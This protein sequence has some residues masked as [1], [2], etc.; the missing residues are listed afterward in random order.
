MVSTR[1]LS[2]EDWQ[3]VPLSTL[4]AFGSGRELLRGADR[5]HVYVEEGK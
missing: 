1:P 2:D 4:I 3:P 5:K